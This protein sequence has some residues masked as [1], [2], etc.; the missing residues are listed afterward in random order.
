[1]HKSFTY[2]GIVDILVRV[3]VRFWHSVWLNC[4]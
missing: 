4:L 2:F 1:M 3:Y